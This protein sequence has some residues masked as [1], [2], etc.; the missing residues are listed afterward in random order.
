MQELESKWRAASG[1]RLPR[2]ERSSAAARVL[3]PSGPGVIR[4]A[5]VGG[6]AGDG[7]AGVAAARAAP[8]LDGAAA[9]GALAAGRGGAGRAGR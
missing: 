5:A 9:G 2:S 7:G 8:A 4:E 3:C 6:R 1:E